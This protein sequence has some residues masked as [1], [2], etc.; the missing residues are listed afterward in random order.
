MPSRLEGSYACFDHFLNVITR[1]GEPLGYQGTSMKVRML[2][3]HAVLPVATDCLFVNSKTSTLSNIKED[4]LW[5]AQPMHSPCTAQQQSMSKMHVHNIKHCLHA[6]TCFTPLR[7]T[8]RYQAKAVCNKKR[9]AY[10]M[11]AS[12]MQATSQIMSLLQAGL[13]V[14]SPDMTY[15][16]VGFS[17]GELL[18]LRFTFAQLSCTASTILCTGLAG[19]CISCS[20]LSVIV[21]CSLC[22]QVKQHAQCA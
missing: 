10:L 12:S 4:C 13:P 16:L 7:M 8:V 17:K 22:V 21:A 15:H 3:P 14:S 11:Q 5:N 9:T 1:S 20:S 2:Q 18:H 19:T 6:I